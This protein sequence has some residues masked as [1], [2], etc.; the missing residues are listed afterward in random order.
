MANDVL[1]AT[2]QDEVYSSNRLPGYFF[3]GDFYVMLE[4][5]DKLPSRGTVI[6]IGT[7]LGR[8]AKFWAELFRQQNKIYNIICLDTYDNTADDVFNQHLRSKFAG[9]IATVTSFLHKK[10]TNLEIV[11]DNLKQYGEIQHYVYDI[12]VN[13][14]EDIQASN[15]V[16]VFDDA[17]HTRQGV[18]QSFDSWFN[19]LEYDGIYC[20]HDYSLNFLEVMETVN[21]IAAENDLKLQ[22]PRKD[23]SMYYLIKKRV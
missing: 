13:S 17:V 12:F 7:F 10:K 19:R 11:I 22:L 6:Q 20:G 18:K 2:N 5:I 23:S 8:S 3:L 1:T 9:D 14:P 16:C 15:I 4:I 21:N